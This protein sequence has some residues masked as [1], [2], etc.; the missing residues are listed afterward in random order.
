MKICVKRVFGLFS[1][2]KVTNPRVLLFVAGSSLEVGR[3]HAAEC[4]VAVQA[5]LRHES[6]R[7]R[8]NRV[9]S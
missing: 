2:V 3:C 6:G 5:E 9:P 4:R 7:T 1:F 8:K